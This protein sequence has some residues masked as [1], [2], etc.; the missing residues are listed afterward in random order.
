VT[1]EALHAVDPINHGPLRGN[2]LGAFFGWPTSPETESLRDAWFDVSGLAEQRK[3]CADIQRTAWNQVP[4][5]PLAHWLVADSVD[6]EQPFRPIAI[7]DSG[8]PDH[9]VHYA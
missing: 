9:A 2:G 5:I 7:T 6:P 1:F 8:D 4:Y 3:I